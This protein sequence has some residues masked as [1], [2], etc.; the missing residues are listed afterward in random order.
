MGNFNLTCRTKEG[1]YELHV[2][3]FEL[4]AGVI[5]HSRGFLS[6]KKVGLSNKFSG[7]QDQT[8]VHYTSVERMV[9]TYREMI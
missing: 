6:G 1:P 3:Y 2:W 9:P 5:F 8:T 4:G 7:L